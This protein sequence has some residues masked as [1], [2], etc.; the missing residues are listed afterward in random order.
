M[1]AQR[2]LRIAIVA[3][4]VIV[5]LVAGYGA[6][7]NEASRRHIDKMAAAQ[8]TVLP[9]T[10]AGYRD[11]HAVVKD[12]S[13]TTRALWTID[14]TAQYEGVIQTVQAYVGQRIHEGDVLATMTN[15]DLL[16]SIASAEADIEGAR[17]TA[18]NYAQT[19]ERYKYLVEHNAISQQEYDSAVAQR[20]AA[21]AKLENK[22]AQR[23]L[24]RAEEEKMIISA[25]QDANIIQI[26]REAGKYVR[27]GEGL[28]MLADLRQLNAVSVLPHQK[29]LELLAMGDH[30]IVQIPTHRLTHKAYPFDK[31]RL[32]SDLKLNQFA[33]KLQHIYPSA[34]SQSDYHQVLWEVENPGGIMEPTY[35]DKVEVL[36][37]KTIRALA[38]PLACVHGMEKDGKA[39]VFTLDN[40]SRLARQTVT[41]GI[42]DENMVEITGGLREGDLVVVATPADYTEGMKVEAREYEF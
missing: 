42:S 28:F 4:I 27:A 2:Y 36:S 41:C 39:S 19:A 1:E 32:P 34:D 23:D 35:Y 12:V 21:R 9:V 33:M 40:E 3:I 38:V 30:F 18:L 20:D 11:I 14:V 26:Y 29:L 13:I 15:N 7:I 8:Y 22:I 17:A 6:Y 37:R 5:I 10:R 16:A 25:P 24:V 31:Q